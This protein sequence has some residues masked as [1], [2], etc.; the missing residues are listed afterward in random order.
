MACRLCTERSIAS[1]VAA[2]NLLVRGL[3][4]LLGERTRVFAGLFTP[5]AEARIGR[6]GIVR[7]RG[8][9]FENASRA[10]LS[11]KRRVLGVIKVLRLFFSVQVIEVAE[12]LIEA[13]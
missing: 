7:S 9:A 10:K 5:R 4:A 12:E 6:R 11:K 1:R 3:H 2:R 13:V 8:F